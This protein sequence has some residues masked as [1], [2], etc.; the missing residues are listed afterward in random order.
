LHRERPVSRPAFFF[1][2]VA[3]Q[4]PRIGLPTACAAERLNLR[5]ARQTRPSVSRR[6]GLVFLCLAKRSLFGAPLG[7]FIHFLSLGAFALYPVMC[8]IGGAWRH[9]FILR[10]EEKRAAKTIAS[11]A[12]FLCNLF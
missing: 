11:A 4:K 3:A 6:L 7:L 5:P 1:V 8:I 10:I 9:N 2:S 12:S